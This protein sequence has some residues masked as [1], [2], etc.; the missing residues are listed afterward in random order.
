MNKWRKSLSSLIVILVCSMLLFVACEPVEGIDLDEVMLSSIEMESY[1]GE[2]TVSLEVLMDDSMISLFAAENPALVMLAEGITVHI[3]ELK[4]ESFESASMNGEV[5]LGDISVPFQISTTMEEMVIEIEGMEKPLVI[6]TFM[7]DAE[8]ALYDELTEHLSSNYQATAEA[9]MDYLV[10]N[11]PNVEMIDVEKT[12][13]VLHEEDTEVHKVHAEIYGDEIL[14]LVNIFLQ[15]LAEDEEGLRELLDVLYDYTLPVFE[16]VVDEMSAYA[17]DESEMDTVSEWLKAYLSNKTLVTEFQY[18]TITQGLKT[19]LDQFDTIT[20]SLENGEMTGGVKLF[21][22]ASYLKTDLYIND[23]SQMVRSDYE[24]LI[25][26]E[27]PFI[28]EG[29]EGIKITSSQSIWNINEPVEASLLNSDNGI[30]LND[31]YASEAILSSIDSESE[32]GQ[33]FKETGLNK[34]QIFLLLGE[35]EY[36]WSSGYLEQGTAMYDSYELAYELGLEHSYHYDEEQVI[37]T[38]PSTGDHLTFTAGE[39]YMYVNGEQIAVN[40]GARTVDYSMYLPIRAVAEAF[41]YEVEW[42][43]DFQMVIITKTYF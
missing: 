8:F 29:F 43:E 14:D 12:S 24:L 23:D 27:I 32:L 3:H 35:N 2:A 31:T 13:I 39:D 36:G 20:E 38:D 42:D 17:T 5:T 1:E 21:T 34:K 16:A 19:A 6:E 41:G 28:G 4:Q 37:L 22:D 25:A 30:S 9:M 18:T 7:D 26:P 11:L 15:N 10:P 40:I 33:F